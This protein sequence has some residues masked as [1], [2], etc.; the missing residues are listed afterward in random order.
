MC[1]HDDHSKATYNHSMDIVQFNWI[2]AIIIICK[3]LRSI[4]IWG[5][6]HKKQ[7]YSEVQISVTH[8]NFV[9]VANMWLLGKSTEKKHDI[10]ELASRNKES[11]GRTGEKSNK[12]KETNMIKELTKMTVIGKIEMKKTFYLLCYLIACKMKTKK[13]T[14][15]YFWCIMHTQLYLY[16]HSTC[17]Y[18][19]EFF[20]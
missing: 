3:M 14:S 10:G 6:S 12:M 11:D 1:I 19:E 7:I 20:W 5:I 17:T 4:Y 8:A 13:Y 15:E 18:I 16:Q 9:Y 2:A